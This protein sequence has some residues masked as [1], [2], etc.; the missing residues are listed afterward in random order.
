MSDSGRTVFAWWWRLTFG[1]HKDAG[2]GY[3][4][5]VRR[6]V[7]WRWGRTDA[8]DLVHDA[9]AALWVSPRLYEF[10]TFKTLLPRKALR[11]AAT[12]YRHRVAHPVTELPDD[13]VDE[14]DDPHQRLERIG[15]GGPRK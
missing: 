6:L 2:E 8:G 10:Q 14:K 7:A 3:Y 4:V 11:L 5:R 1:D 12:R 9:F 13:L 15:R